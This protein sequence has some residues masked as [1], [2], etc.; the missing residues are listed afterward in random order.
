MT[1]RL[2]TGKQKATPDQRDVRL[3]MVVDVE[4]VMPKLPKTFGHETGFPYAM[5]GNGPDDTVRKG[6]GGAGC[7]VFSGTAEETHLIEHAAK[8][9]LAALTG[10]EVIAA[11]SEVTGYVIG[12]ESTDQG[13]N[14]RKA[15]AWRRKVGIAD[16]T[17]KRHKIGAFLALDPGNLLH[18]EIA[19]RLFGAVGIGINFPQ[20]AMDQFNAGEPWTLVPGS[21]DGG[22]HY[23]PVVAKRNASSLQVLTWA[24]DQRMSLDFY[25]A[26]C[27]EAWAIVPTEYLDESGKTPEGFDQAAL[28]GYLSA[29]G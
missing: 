17:G 24:K 15:L 10:K 27:D 20:S 26:Q 25:Q 5:L 2:Y 21:P 13:T 11:Y 14:V 7:C 6:F 4:R 19:L 9:K 8:R 16:A 18:V 23:V 1:A 29:L 3:G 22:G 12:D 28:N